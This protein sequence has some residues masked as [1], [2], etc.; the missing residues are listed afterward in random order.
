[1]GETG[2]FVAFSYKFYVRGN[3]KLL[4]FKFKTIAEIDAAV[5]CFGVLYLS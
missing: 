5:R 4:A 2:C 3:L 1:M